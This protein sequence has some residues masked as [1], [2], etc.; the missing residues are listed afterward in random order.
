MPYMV[1]DAIREVCGSTDWRSGLLPSIKKW[2]Q[3]VSGDQGSY[4]RAVGCGFCIVQNNRD[5]FSEEG[6]QFNCP[7]HD[8]CISAINGADSEEVLR[9]LLDLA[10]RMGKE[11]YDGAY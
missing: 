10:Q 7:A 2:E 9:G 8:I 4:P 1:S 6:C 3:I 5:R 11:E